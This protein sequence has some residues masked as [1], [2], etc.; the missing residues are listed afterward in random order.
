MSHQLK[1]M[2]Q[3]VGMEYKV[4]NLMRSTSFSIKYIFMDFIDINDVVS[5]FDTHYTVVYYN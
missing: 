2:E 4:V 5:T 1:M 3:S